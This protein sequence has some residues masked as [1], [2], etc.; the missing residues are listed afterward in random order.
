[1]NLD[2][3]EYQLWSTVSI[4]K[5]KIT[6]GKVLVHEIAM[7]LI[8]LTVCFTSRRKYLFGIYSC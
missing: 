8:L 1:M 3:I 4:R 5:K 2:V 7:L 6:I